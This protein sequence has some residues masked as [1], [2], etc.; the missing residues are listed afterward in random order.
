MLL[1]PPYGLLLLPPQPPL[2]PSAAERHQQPTSN[3]FFFQAAPLHCP[4][5]TPPMLKLTLSVAVL[6]AA[7]L[8]A[9]PALAEGDDVVVL[10]AKVAFPHVPLNRQ[11]LLLLLFVDYLTP[12]T[13]SQPQLPEL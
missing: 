13:P 4:E 9:T 1:L 12:S 11:T 2:L 7:L 8:L 3:P 5:K 10:T 6:C